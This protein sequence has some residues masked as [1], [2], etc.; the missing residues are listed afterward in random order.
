MHTN[1]TFLKV[2]LLDASQYKSDISGGAQGVCPFCPTMVCELRYTLAI[3]PESP[4]SRFDS[5]SPFVYNSGYKE[6]RESP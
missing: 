5:V 2:F 1:R 3:C 4:D 6:V